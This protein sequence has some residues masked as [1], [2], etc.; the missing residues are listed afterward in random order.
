MEVV[1]NAKI[2]HNVNWKKNEEIWEKG[3]DDPGDD[4]R[5]QKIKKSLAN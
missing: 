4:R 2:A 1:A 3:S 5:Q